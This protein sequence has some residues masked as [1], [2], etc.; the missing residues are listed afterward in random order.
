[1]SLDPNPQPKPNLNNPNKLLNT[2]YY[3]LAYNVR[4]GWLST[5]NSCRQ[6]SYT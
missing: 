6:L 4:Y 2:T 5:T 1:M 3:L